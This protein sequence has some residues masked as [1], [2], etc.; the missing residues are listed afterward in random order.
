MAVLAE[1]EVYEDY[2]N[3]VNAPYEKLLASSADPKFMRG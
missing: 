1:D 3:D 2:E